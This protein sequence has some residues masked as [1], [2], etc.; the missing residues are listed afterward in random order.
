MLFSKRNKVALNP[1]SALRYD[2]PVEFRNQVVHL[3]QQSMGYS[4][5]PHVGRVAHY[6]EDRLRTTQQI[7]HNYAFVYRDLCEE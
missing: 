6:Y 7:H 5:E 2:L 4:E 1:P 3:W